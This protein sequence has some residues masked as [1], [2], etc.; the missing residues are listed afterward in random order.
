MTEGCLTG[1]LLPT[2]EPSEVRSRGGRVVSVAAASEVVEDD[3]WLAPGLLD[4]QVNGFGGHNLNGVHPSAEAV[5]SIRAVLRAGG[6]TAF[7]PTVVTD[8]E[9]AMCERLAAIDSACRADADLARDLPCIHLEGPFLSPDDGPRGAHPAEHVRPADLEAFERLQRAAG[10]RIGIVTLAPEVPG[11]LELTRALSAS[12]ILV[13]IGHSGASPECVREAVA[14]GARLSTHLGNG[15]HA[16]L[17]RHPNYIWEQLAADEL[18][19]T[20]IPDG[21]HLPPAVV[22]CFLRAKGLAR[23]ILV[24]DAVHLAGLAP[25]TYGFVGHEVELLA[26]G[27]I[28]LA[29]TPYLAGSSLALLDGVWNASRYAGISLAEAWALASANPWHLL[30]VRDRGTIA[31]GARTDLVRLRLPAE[32]PPEVLEVLSATGASS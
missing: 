5:R 29:G 12:G 32:G 11:G 27:R 24:S 7:C 31:P 9:E 19:A 15:A 14:A 13:A 26:S 2:G 23:S 22:R 17:P 8:A 18:D 25:G 1:R 30:G 3:V 10:G 4:L 16:V 20:I 6:V 28:N 21:H